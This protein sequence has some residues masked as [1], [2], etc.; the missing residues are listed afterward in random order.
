MIWLFLQ[1]TRMSTPVAAREAI[2][3]RAVKPRSSRRIIPA[4]RLRPRCGA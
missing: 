1:R 3:S 4:R 2:S